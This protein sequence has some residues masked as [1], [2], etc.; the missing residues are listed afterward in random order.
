MTD[1]VTKK[2][3]TVSDREPTRQRAPDSPA[4]PELEDDSDHEGGTEEQVGDRTG[5]GAGYDKEPEQTDDPGGV[6]TAA[7]AG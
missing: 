6:T 5:P 4:I 1:E 2:P 3:P 7:P